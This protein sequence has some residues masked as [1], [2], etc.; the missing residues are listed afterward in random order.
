MARTFN[1]KTWIINALRRASFRYPPAIKAIKKARTE[2]YIKAKNGNDVKR[3]DFTCQVC[4]K[5][6]LKR[7]EVNLDHIIP[8]VGPEGF[9]DW[10][11]YIERMFCDESNYQIICISCHD[12]KSSREREEK[13]A[14]KSINKS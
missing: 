10:N 4:N 13:E 7:K 1:K 5:A 2:Y 14:F 12:E 9:I 3:V 6:G 11:N 8:V